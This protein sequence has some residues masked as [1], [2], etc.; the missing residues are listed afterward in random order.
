[1]ER[2]TYQG[3]H[4]EWKRII[5]LLEDIRDHLGKPQSLP[6]GALEALSPQTAMAQ[7]MSKAARHG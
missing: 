1:M 4:D 5:R 3:E 2:S 6:N 7:A